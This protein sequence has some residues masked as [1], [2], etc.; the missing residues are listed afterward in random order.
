MTVK[1]DLDICDGCGECETA[2][3]V[4]AIIVKTKAQMIE[5]ACTKCG[6]CIEKCPLQALSLDSVVSV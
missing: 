1:I 4:L 6:I 3:P 5:E 2:C